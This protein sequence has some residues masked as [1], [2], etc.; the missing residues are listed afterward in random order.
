[1]TFTFQSSYVFYPRK[2]N[3]GPV[4]VKL[5]IDPF[6]TSLDG[7]IC[8]EAV[9]RQESLSSAASQSESGVNGELLKEMESKKLRE[10]LSDTQRGSQD[11]Q[12]AARS[13]V[14]ILDSLDPE[15]DTSLHIEDLEIGG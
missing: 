2:C 13:C 4:V 9:A 1:M 8:G 5:L 12:H 3:P 6:F 11:S 14:E 15:F 10:D 7:A